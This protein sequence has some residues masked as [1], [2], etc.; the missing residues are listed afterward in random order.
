MSPHFLYRT[1]VSHPLRFIFDGQAN[2]SAL[3]MVVF[4]NP[5]TL[6]FLV[7][8]ITGVT[9]DTTARRERHT[10]TSMIV[11]LARTQIR[12]ISPPPLSAGQSLP[13]FFGM[14]ASADPYLFAPI[15]A[16][17]ETEADS[18]TSCRRHHRC[19]WPSSYF[20]L[21]VE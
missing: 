5:A 13:L 1:F 12:R 20:L 15:L 7:R 18:E 10:P 6:T 8:T 16:G 19:S 2:S 11:L 4:S 14:H 3:F 21:F 9:R 17:K